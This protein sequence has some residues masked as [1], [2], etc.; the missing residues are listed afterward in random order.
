MVVASI[1]II[2]K[3]TYRK[4]DE[5]SEMTGAYKAY[6]IHVGKDTGY[7]RECE[8]ISD[9]LKW[10]A[11]D[12]MNYLEEKIGL[13][14]KD[15]E[16]FS[17]LID[18]AYS[19]IDCLETAAEKFM[20]GE[21][22]EEGAYIIRSDTNYIKTMN[23]FGENRNPR[24]DFHFFK[25][26]R[27][28]ISA[29][30]FQTNRDHIKKFLQVNYA[31]CKCVDY[32]DPAEASEPDFCIS[33]SADNLVLF[34]IKSD[35]IWEYV[36]SRYCQLVNTIYMVM[37]QRIKRITV[38][39]FEKVIDLGCTSN[40]E[41]IGRLI[42]V[43]FNRQIGYKYSRRSLKTALQ[44]DFFQSVRKRS[45]HSVSAVDLETDRLI[46]SNIQSVKKECDDNHCIHHGAHYN[47]VEFDNN[48]LSKFS[49]FYCSVSYNKRYVRVLTPKKDDCCRNYTYQTIIK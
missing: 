32:K 11:K 34:D 39:K 45:Q 19:I 14:I 27:S 29:H 8:S 33:V 40:V 16:T 37:K 13:G 4:L 21:K 30:P 26:L 36:R 25:F 7:L 2:N 38:H 48:Q 31:C 9:S 15:S 12:R 46:H 42:D 23:F 5:I 17:V 22:N 49:E 18:L 6:L 44:C 28:L 3:N 47:S 43:Y 20:I 10:Q 24:D 41:Q 1:V 35:E